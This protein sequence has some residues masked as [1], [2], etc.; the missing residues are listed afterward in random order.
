VGGEKNPHMKEAFELAAILILNFRH[1]TN[2]SHLRVAITTPIKLQKYRQILLSS[3]LGL[4]QKPKWPYAT[5]FFCESYDL[6][7]FHF[8]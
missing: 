1:R 8:P 3:F 7:T 6:C 4:T 2:I 5:L